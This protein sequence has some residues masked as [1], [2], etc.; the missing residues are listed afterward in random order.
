M[1]QQAVLALA[2]K[3]ARERGFNVTQLPGRGKG[4]HTM[5]AIIDQHG[6]E[7]GRMTL[8]TGSKDITWTVLR[9]TEAALSHILGE[10]WMKK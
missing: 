4:S 1:K 3:A 10:K 6:A 2:R 5:W 8:T 7:V 9:T